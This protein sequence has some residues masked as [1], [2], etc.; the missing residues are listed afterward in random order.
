[1][2]DTGKRRLRRAVSR[3]EV[4]ALSL[5]D[6]VGSGVY[7]LPAVAAALLG[8]ASLWAVALAGAAVCLVVLCFAEAS[9]YFEEPGSAYLYTR[10]A[11]G[12]LPGF[13]VGWMT[14][15]ARVASLASLAGGFA[16]ALSYLWPAAASGWGRVAAIVVPVLVLTWINVV[17]VKSGAR[18]ATVLVV[19]KIAPLVVLLAAG[20]LAGSSEMA[21]AQEITK[22]GGLGEAALLLLF[23]YAGFENTA[24]AAGEFKSPRRDVPFALVAQI[25]I[26]TALYAAVQWVA[27]ATV[28]GLGATEAP[29][30]ESAERVLGGWGATMLTVGAVVSILGTNGNTVLAG[31]RY[32]YALARDGY[33]PR[34][35]AR[36]HPR[37][38]TP[39]A[40]ILVQTALALPLAVAGSFEG[41]AAVSVVTRLVSY[42]GTALSVPVLRRRL[43]GVSRFRLPAGPLIPLA[44]TA[45]TV[46]LA[47]SA[48]RKHLVAAAVALATGLV[49][50]RLRRADDSGAGS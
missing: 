5:N 33:G 41:L 40:A 34:F 3:W 28:P 36:V 9:S 30:A 44:A 26:V 6:V 11:F 38:R 39:A 14:W 31:P 49:L 7:L 46:G 29:L 8:F 18:A 43:A 35:L 13:A 20:F 12:E 10:T 47:A 45:L 1:M 48:E 17:G 2:I 27:L 16:L 24:A 42:A 37:Y 4:L 23:A 22:P 25:A 50:Y 21:F 32:L 15:L 19:A